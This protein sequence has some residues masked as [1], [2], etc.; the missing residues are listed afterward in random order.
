[1]AHVCCAAH[2]PVGGGAELSHKPEE[3]MKRFKNSPAQ[4]GIP[5]AVVFSGG[6][7]FIPER[8]SW[9][10]TTGGHA[11][12]NL[13]RKCWQ[14]SLVSGLWES[15]VALAVRQP[16]DDS[17]ENTL[18]EGAKSDVLQRTRIQQAVTTLKVESDF[19]DLIKA[20]KLRAYTRA[21]QLKWY[22]HDAWKAGF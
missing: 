7:K 3:S 21:A 16:G 1:M 8:K 15:H 10:R 20:W 22:M 5:G 11:H 17:T 19:T 12:C 9:G 14:L 13:R 2:P 4:Q 6:D 18:W